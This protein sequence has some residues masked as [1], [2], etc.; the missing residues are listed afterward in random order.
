MIA[1]YSS[2][3]ASHTAVFHKVT[4]VSWLYM[5][6][7]SPVVI[8]GTLVSPIPKGHF[9]PSPPCELFT[10][11]YTFNEG[12]GWVRFVWPSWVPMALIAILI[13]NPSKRKD[14]QDAPPLSF[15]QTI[16]FSFSFLC[17]AVWG[18]QCP[19]TMNFFSTEH[20]IDINIF[21]TDSIHHFLNVLSS[22]LINKTP[23]CVSRL[24][25]HRRIT[26]MSKGCGTKPYVFILLYL[27]SLKIIYFLP[28]TIYKITSM[29]SCWATQSNISH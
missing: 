15:P 2:R 11:S 19:L 21:C 8:M 9:F 29:S 12:R 16:F 24:T 10:A 14:E 6:T 25:D 18:E 28:V 3:T 23:I 1:T 27:S 17:R 20:S 26:S 13:M 22:H 4:G 5:S 7:S